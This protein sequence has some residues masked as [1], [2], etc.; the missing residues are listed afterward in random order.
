MA[1]TYVIEEIEEIGDD[2]LPGLANAY[3]DLSHG[4]RTAG[5]ASDSMFQE[6]TVTSNT[7]PGSGGTPDSARQ[8]QLKSRL[9]GAPCS[10]ASWAASMI[11]HRTWNI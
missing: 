5:S 8:V 2:V 1:R 3:L 10:C 6:A 9:P 11:P 4:A 7:G